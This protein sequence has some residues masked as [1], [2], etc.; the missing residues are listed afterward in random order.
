MKNR[1]KSIK[2]AIIGLRITAAEEPNFRVHIAISAIVIVLGIIVKISH[3]EWLILILTIGLVLVS[4][5]FNTAIEDLCDY[6]NKEF[7]ELIGRIKNISAGA[8]L[9]SAIISFIVGLIIFIPY[10]ISL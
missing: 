1:L 7:D 3:T 5:V 9:T 2:A 8:V 6:N 10:F 4:E